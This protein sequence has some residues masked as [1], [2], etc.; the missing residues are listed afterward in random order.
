M[1][2]LSE[3][4]ISE[5]KEAFILFDR[6]KDGKITV[7]EFAVI[8][9]AL[10][11][12]PSEADIRDYARQVSSEDGLI[13]LDDFLV[14]M[15]KQMKKPVDTVEEL[16]E[17]FRVFDRDGTGYISTVELRHIMT[18]LGEK[19]SEEE[20]NEMMKIADPNNTGKINYDEFAK[21]LTSQ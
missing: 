12:S 7:K 15:A 9:R 5:L 1:E 10:G 3:E 11:Q 14:C 8:M 13:L 2:N 4:Q 16:K 6:D 18:T 21:F 20:A 17:A 19:L